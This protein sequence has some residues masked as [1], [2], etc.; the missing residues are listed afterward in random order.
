M[1]LNSAQEDKSFYN[2]DQAL[3]RMIAL[4]DKMKKANGT[5]FYC[6]RDGVFYVSQ[7]IDFKESREL[8]P[9]NLSSV[10]DWIKA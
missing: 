10:S 9:N 4:G 1:L 8:N 7:T 3:I 6:Y 5:Q 2:K